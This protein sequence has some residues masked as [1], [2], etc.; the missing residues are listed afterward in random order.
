M[1]DLVETMAYTVERGVPWHGKGNGVSGLQTAEEMLKA[2][3]LDWEVSLVPL[4]T[5]TGLAIDSKVAVV[6][7]TDAKVL[8]VVG[9]VYKPV[10]NLQGFEFAN[11]LVADTG[12]IFE[13]AG[14]LD[15][16]RTIF[17]SV[18]LSGVEPI[19]IDGD[20]T[21]DTYLVIS[22]THDGTKALRGTVTPVRT[23]CWNTLN[24]AFGGAKNVFTIRHSGDIAGKME[25][26]R[27]ALNISIDYMRRFEE[28]AQK[29]I[30]KKVTEAEAEAIIRDAFL[31]PKSVE[32]NV[33]TKWY[34]NHHSTKAI[35]VLNTT[36][37]LKPFRDTGWGVLNAVAEYVD[38]DRTYGKIAD[39][40]AL[41][42]K[43][44]SILWGESND[45]LN[46]TAALIL[47]DTMQSKIVAE[48][49]KTAKRVKVASK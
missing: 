33:D 3:G 21:F 48:A 35:E 14:S 45:V 16:G 2:S 31:M 23:V 41:D 32:E 24:L 38:H 19:R 39:R 6:R 8:G 11:G 30:D 42:V 9:N 37:D 47:P 17:L 28:T 1:P 26:A 44:T 15:E 20:S 36:A 34:G 49:R 22:N 13:T 43:A 12:N 4:Q 7:E 18:D 46:R 40:D 5:I 25:Q 10:Q 29:F 27:K